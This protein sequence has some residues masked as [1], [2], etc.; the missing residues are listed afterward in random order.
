MR[1]TYLTGQAPMTAQLGPVVVSVPGPPGPP[2]DTTELNAA[3]AAAALE[4]E[5]ARTA[6]STAEAVAGPEIAERKELIVPETTDRGYTTEFVAK[7]ESVQ[8][9]RR[10]LGGF[11]RSDGALEVARV[12]VRNLAGALVPSRWLQRYESDT[13]LP[14]IAWDYRGRFRAQP[15]EATLAYIGANIPGIGAANDY[16]MLQMSG[17][18]FHKPVASIMGIS[19]Y[20]Q[21][22]NARNGQ[23][24]PAQNDLNGYTLTGARFPKNAITLDDGKGFLGW[25]GP[26]PASHTNASDFIAA[27]ELVSQIQT[28][29][30]AMAFRM[31]QQANDQAAPLAVFARSEAR[32][33]TAI[34]ALMPL[35][36]AFPEAVDG[37]PWHAWE[38]SIINAQAIAVAKGTTCTIRFI[39]WV[40]GQSNIDDTYGAYMDKVTRLLNY[41]QDRVVA[42]TGQARKP[43]ILI[44]QQPSS[45]TK[46]YSDTFRV[47][48]DICLQRTDATLVTGGYGHE[49][50]DVVHGNRWTTVEWGEL[51]AATADL[52]LRG[53]PADAPMLTKPR[54]SGRVITFDVAGAWDVV[55]D[56]SIVNDRHYINGTYDAVTGAYTGGIPVPF[57]GFEASLGA[58]LVTIE[59]VQVERRRITVTLAATPT[60]GTLQI[61]YAMHNNMSNTSARGDGRSANR[62]NIRADYEV[63]S[64]LVQG[65]RNLRWM[66]SNFFNFTT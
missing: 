4:A 1:V 64:M 40:H 5:A 58:S 39:H 45:T 8:G 18:S 59:S 35:I 57:Y 13:G 62:G 65:R 10:S 33:E 21:S 66:A 48:A 26:A 28:P 55:A 30:G 11:R 24:S 46:G 17:G 56:E 60:S 23:G 41:M 61:R 9:R 52:V 49:Q 29:V 31:A 44:I 63:P 34:E 27:Q 19:A 43:H 42:I 38:R 16:P 7:S 47:A 22:W 53:Q 14:L 50:I 20:G 54:R 36:P 25:E 37:G 51:S 6:A 12:V 3:V 15:D 2:A 32:G